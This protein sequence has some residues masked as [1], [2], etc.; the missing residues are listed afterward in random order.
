MSGVKPSELPEAWDGIAIKWTEDWAPEPAAIKTA[1]RLLETTKGKIPKPETAA[2][3]YWPNVLFGWPSREIEVE[4]FAGHCE[5][6]QF[7]GGNLTGT[8]IPSF[9]ATRTGIAPLLAAFGVI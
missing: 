8:D 4:V 7:K 1:T 9:K 3:G 6:Y 2:R 5:L